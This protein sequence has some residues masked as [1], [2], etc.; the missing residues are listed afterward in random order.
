VARAPEARGITENTEITEITEITP[1]NDAEQS[2][3]QTRRGTAQVVE[4]VNAAEAANPVQVNLA[5]RPRPE[6]TGKP[7]PPPRAET[8]PARPGQYTRRSGRDGHREARG[9][10]QAHP[11]NPDAECLPPSEFRPTRPCPT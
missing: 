1:K 5:Q 8:D 10:G 2:T 3:Q 4:A 11:V 9:D 6:I 7:R